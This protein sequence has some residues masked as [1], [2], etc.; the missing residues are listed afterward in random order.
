[1]PT[2]PELLTGGLAF[3][4][5][6]VVMPDGSVI[7]VEIVGQRLTRVW[8]DGRTEKICDIPGGPAGAALGPDGAI[9]VCNI[10]GM[11]FSRG[12]CVEG[13]GNEGRIERVDLSTGRLERLYDHCG[14]RPLQ[15]P[16]DL[17]FDQEGNFWFSDM[18][19]E[20]GDRRTYGGIYYASPDGK[21]IK[22]AFHPL[23]SPNGIGLSPDQNTLYAADTI[24][25]RVWAMDIIGAGMIA[26]A[27]FHQP[28]RLLATVPHGGQ[29]DSMA[30]TA[31]GNIVQGMLN[32]GGLASI[33]L[34][35]NVEYRLFEGQQYV[36]NIA[37]G[38]E[39]MRDAYVTFS[40]TGCLRWPEPGLLLNFSGRA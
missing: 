37:F 22:Q 35:G 21:T 34:N 27:S 38:G 17:V 33:S 8:G 4:E 36:T 6:P 16:D 19:K 29:C 30:V 23:Y 9:Y 7:L 25:A 12:I 18:G 5:G 28:G 13:P 40:G 2:S 15:S 26:Q 31:A 20:L 3:P 39:D 11:D 10:G 1:V 14:D 24:T 32:P